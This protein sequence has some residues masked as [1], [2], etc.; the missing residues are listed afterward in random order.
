MYI[1]P[2]AELLKRIS[3]LPDGYRGNA[4]LVLCDIVD[5]FA[6]ATKKHNPMHSGH[7]GY[8][9]ILEELEEAWDEIKADSGEAGSEIVQVG[10]M[11]VRYLC[12]LH[13]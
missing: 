7:E 13:M 8:S 1:D 2:A 9:V 5:E 10:A 4:A 6:K 12:D 11:A 3:N